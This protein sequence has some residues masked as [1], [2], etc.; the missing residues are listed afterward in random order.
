MM[1]PQAQREPGNEPQAVRIIELNSDDWNTVQWTRRKVQ[2]LKCYVHAIR[3]DQRTW[4]NDGTQGAIFTHLRQYRRL[5]F[6][7]KSF[8]VFKRLVGLS[9][10][11]IAQDGKRKYWWSPLHLQFTTPEPGCPGCGTKIKS[12]CRPVQCP[13]CNTHVSTM[14]L[15]TPSLPHT[16]RQELVA[17]LEE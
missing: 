15:C 11:I 17:L 3:W 13:N 7:E 8:G 14:I 4:N 12:N 10:D 5:A 1:P 2:F 9:I 6:D 16:R